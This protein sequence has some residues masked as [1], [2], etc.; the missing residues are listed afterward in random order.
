MDDE[1]L[2][3]V[4]ADVE[5]ELGTAWG[6]AVEWL[7]EQNGIDDLEA[8]LSG[9]LSEIGTGIDDAAGSFAAAEV[10]GFATAARA[11]ATWLDARVPDRLITY[12]PATAAAL[13]WVERNRLEIVG[14]LG[15]EQRA[16]IR[17]AISEGVR[18]GHNPREVARGIREVLGLTEHQAAHV[19]SYRRALETGDFANALA[20][21]L[22][23][24]RS[25]RTLRVAMRDGEAIDAAQID[26]MVERYRRNY[27]TFRAETIAR[28]E[29]LRVVHQGA[30]EMLQQAIEAAQ[31]EVG[32]IELVWLAGAPPRTRNWH[33]VM[34]GQ[35]RRIG[36]PF[37]S[38]Q[39][40]ALRYPGD[41]NAPASET[42]S[43]RCRRS[44][45]YKPTAT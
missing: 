11:T 40:N 6:D 37:E 3:E 44:A 25:D 39:G 34:N 41:P 12:N 22:R 1:Q 32:S 36:E 24:G 29:A 2:S 16:V 4:L 19:A 9:D 27:V 20:R 17:N 18:L 45:R 28:T 8:A 14:G 26:A 42:V 10:D 38:G 43:C 5:S 15:Q 35:T 13:R 23:D 33:A 30:D 21:E 7:R 31:I